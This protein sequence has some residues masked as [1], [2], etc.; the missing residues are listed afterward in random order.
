MREII[1]MFTFRKWLNET[2][3]LVE[4]ERSFFETD[5]WYRKRIELE[6]D[7]KIRKMNII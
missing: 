3:K 4:T 2:G 6:I 1:S 7:R 5:Y